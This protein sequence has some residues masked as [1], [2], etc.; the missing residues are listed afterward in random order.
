MLFIEWAEA[1]LSLPKAKEHCMEM[2]RQLFLFR[3]CQS[4]IHATWCWRW[5]GLDTNKCQK[6]SFIDMWTMT[7]DLFSETKAA[8][9]ALM[10]GKTCRRKT[11]VS[12]QV[13]ASQ[14]AG[15]AVYGSRT[16]PLRP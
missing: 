8:R 5:H 4:S 14:S 15:P 1:W 3:P 2:T 10:A 13:C 16:L 12:R 6:S 9:S 11:V 7:G